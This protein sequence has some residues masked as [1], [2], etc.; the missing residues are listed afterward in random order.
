MSMTRK[1]AD[2]VLSRADR[3]A[4]RAELRAAFRDHQRLGSALS[5]GVRNGWLRFDGRAWRHTGA[6]MRQ[7]GWAK[8][9]LRRDPEGYDQSYELQRADE[10]F[11]ER[12]GSQRY[13]DVSN[14]G[15]RVAWR[16]LPPAPSNAIG[17]SAALLVG[18]RLR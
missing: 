11:A 2:Y 13:E 14:I 3:C 6:E 8:G 9:V 18:E 4:T 1:V 16:S 12:I 17:C 5:C 7:Q 10:M 15:P